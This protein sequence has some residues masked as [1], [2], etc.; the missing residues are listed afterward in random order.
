MSLTSRAK[1]EIKLRLLPEYGAG[2][3]KVVSEFVTA[4]KPSFA[5]EEG[6][7]YIIR[8]G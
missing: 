1:A 2:V 8:K 5:R 4:I 6:D 3:R 7:P